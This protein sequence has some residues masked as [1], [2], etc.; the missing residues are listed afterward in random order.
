MLSS[1]KFPTSLLGVDASPYAR[2]VWFGLGHLE[3]E[4]RLNQRALLDW[5]LGPAPFLWLPS[6]LQAASLHVQA[7]CARELI[8]WIHHPA[9]WQLHAADSAV[10]RHRTTLTAPG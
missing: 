6:A 1:P 2:L 5:C 3:R 8:R 10:G 4:Q 9:A 7:A